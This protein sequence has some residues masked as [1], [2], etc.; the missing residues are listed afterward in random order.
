MP[1]GQAADW[2]DITAGLQAYFVVAALSWMRCLGA[3]AFF[4]LFFSQ[5]FP[6]QM[7]LAIPV[8]TLPIAMMALLPR[9]EQIQ[10]ASGLTLLIWLAMEF[11]LGVVITLPVGVGFWAAQCAGELIDIKTGAN[12]NAVFGTGVDAPEGPAQLLMA[13]FA[14]LAFVAGQGL[15]AMVGAVWSSYRLVPVGAY[16]RLSA[17]GLPLLAQTLCGEL[18]ELVVR[19]FAPLLVVFLLLEFGIGI[20]GRMAQQLQVNTIAAPMKS[21]LFPLAMIPLLLLGWYLGEP[22]ARALAGME[23]LLRLLLQ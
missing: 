11:I 19:L 8:A 21:L 16:E 3:F 1:D 14:L 6:R 12:N 7:R 2:A 15:Q 9:A 13:Q 10:S 18:M 20:A 23:P 5:P 4:P 17:N 22:M